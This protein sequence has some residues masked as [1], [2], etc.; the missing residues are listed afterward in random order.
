MRRILV[1]HAR[2][3]NRIKR[4]GE[5]NRVPLTPATLKEFGVTESE[6]LSQADYLLA[7]EEG[8]NRL[9]AVDPL[10]VEV[11][12]LRFF[13]GLSIEQTADAMGISS[14]TVCRLWTFARAWLSHEIFENDVAN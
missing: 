14:R 12:D 13:G 1:E 3:K 9:Q 8:L 5:F 11:I 6:R 10:A 4:G 2:S 7:L